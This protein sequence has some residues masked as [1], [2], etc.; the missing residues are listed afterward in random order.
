M[1]YEL[2]AKIFDLQIACNQYK[3]VNQLADWVLFAIKRY[4]YTGR[5]SAAFVR[6]FLNFPTDC[7]HN[8]I[9]KCMDGDMSDDGIM[10]TTKQIIKEDT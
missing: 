9:Q 3:V 6:A 4:I 8:L 2:E 5:A 1:N 10:K 7:F